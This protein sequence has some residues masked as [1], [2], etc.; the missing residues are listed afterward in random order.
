MGRKLT[1]IVCSVLLSGEMCRK[2]WKLRTRTRR[3]ASSVSPGVA[4]INLAAHCRP[5]KF[6]SKYRE[7]R[8]ESLT[9]QR[10]CSLTWTHSSEGSRPG[11]ETEW[12][13][14]IFVFQVLK[15]R[16]GKWFTI[17]LWLNIRLEIDNWHD[18]WISIYIK[19]IFWGHLAGGPLY[20]DNKT[21]STPV[22]PS[23][24]AP[25]WREARRPAQ[26]CRTG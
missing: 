25:T 6:L 3:A 19:L 1:A 15:R 20:C 14:K 17:Y 7:Y 23:S 9:V 13:E 26:Q 16:L 4:V 22:P 5:I 12:T 8:P 21:V 18:L 24:S 11:G 10:S 2:Y